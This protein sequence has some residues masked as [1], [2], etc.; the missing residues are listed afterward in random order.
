MKNLLI[1]LLLLSTSSFSQVLVDRSI[2]GELYIGTY[3]S[4]K[5]EIN[6]EV[7]SGVLTDHKIK[8]F[9]FYTVGN[10]DEI[11]VLR[12]G[13]DIHSVKNEMELLKQ[14]S[15]KNTKILD[16]YYLEESLK[17]I[18]KTIR[19]NKF[20]GLKS[21]NVIFSSDNYGGVWKTLYTYKDVKFDKE[22][23]LMLLKSNETPLSGVLTRNP[24]WN[25]VKI[26]SHYK[27]GKN[28]G[29]FEEYHLN[30]NLKFKGYYKNGQRIGLWKEYYNNGKL[31]MKGE[32]IDN[33]MNNLWEYYYENGKLKMKGNFIDGQ[34]DGLWT[35]YDKYHGIMYS[36]GN[37]KDG[38]K[39]GPWIE[40]LEG[41]SD[42][43]LSFEGNYKDGKKDGLWKYYSF[44]FNF[45]GKL[46]SEGK[47]KDGKK[48][49]LWKNYHTSGQLNS[50]GNYKDGKEEGLWRYYYVTGTLKSEGNY[51]DGKKEGLWRD[52]NYDTFFSV[53]EGNYKD[54]KEE[55]L[56]RYY[57][58]TGQLKSEGNYKDGQEV[59][60]WKYY[61]ENGSLYMKSN[62]SN[63]DPEKC[64]DENGK[65]IECCC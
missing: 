45:K 1:L 18:K 57:Y 44:K 59:G 48:E 23:G 38:Q 40:Y 14:K 4:I 53:S 22:R 34:K 7:I 5:V 51:K 41:N 49:G 9:R 17:T 21:L 39:D 3:P 36:E 31:K 29:S 61:H 58:V 54:G 62:W 33:E 25:T 27:D 32:I 19:K 42:R 12:L 60:L 46:S 10:D 30:G 35:K 55:G 24:D 65:K 63:D 47:Y 37:Y 20:E 11:L 6:N 8:D 50:E 26:E 15:L 16:I 64:W 13:E 28:E 43:K 2:G 56:W 52:N